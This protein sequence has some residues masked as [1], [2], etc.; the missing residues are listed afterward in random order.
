MDFSKQVVE[1]SPDQKKRPETQI[2]EDPV[3]ENKEGDEKVR[4]DLVDIYSE[5]DAYDP[6]KTTSNNSNLTAQTQKI[7]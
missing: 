5:P 4:G 7:A 2:R 1:V 3:E 6:K